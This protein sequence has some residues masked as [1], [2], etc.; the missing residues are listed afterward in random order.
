MRRYWKEQRDLLQDYLNLCWQALKLRWNNSYFQNYCDKHGLF[1]YK[2]RK[3]YL[4]VFESEISLGDTVF[5][6]EMPGFFEKETEIVVRDY[7]SKT[8]VLNHFWENQ[9]RKVRGL[10]YPSLEKV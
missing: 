9:P 4:R 1:S 7:Y 10:G 3:I 8:V 5:P 2:Q 6:L